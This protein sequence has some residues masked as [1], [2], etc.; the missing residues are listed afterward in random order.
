MVTRLVHL[1]RQCQAS[2][3]SGG[4][5]GRCIILSASSPTST[6]MFIRGR[7]RRKLERVLAACITAA[8]RACTRAA[9]C[10]ERV[11]SAVP[12]SCCCCVVLWLHICMP[13]NNGQGKSWANPHVNKIAANGL[14]ITGTTAA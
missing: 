2:L 10:N 4:W 9:K 5:G 8:P 3:P 13:L 7:R 14:A 12:A 11:D 6:P 1:G